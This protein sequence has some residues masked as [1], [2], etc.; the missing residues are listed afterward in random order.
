MKKEPSKLER[1]V[2]IATI[3]GVIITCIALIPAFGQWLYPTQPSTPTILPP[4]QTTNELIPLDVGKS[5]AMA[6]GNSAINYRSLLFTPLEQ[7]NPN[8]YMLISESTLDDEING[9]AC[10]ASIDGTVF[11]KVDGTWVTETQQIGINQLGGYCRAPDGKMIEFGT[12]TYGVL[13]EDGYSGAGILVGR[14]VFI[15]YF[16]NMFKVVLIAA[17][18]FGSNE[19]ECGAKVPCWQ[20]DSKIEFS[21]GENPFFYNITITTS[22]TQNVNNEI[23]N[24]W[25]VQECFFSSSVLEYKCFPR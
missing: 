18:T 2:Q 1:Y 21:Q 19:G 12:D 6:Y 11:K 5:L 23:L 4:S 24:L 25:K 14:Y 10:S 22:G 15:A 17:N 20:Y 3:F 13:F 16:D 9:H 8:K 7:N